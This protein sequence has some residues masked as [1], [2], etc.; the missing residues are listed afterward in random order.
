MILAGSCLRG[1]LQYEVT[2]PLG[3]VASCHCAFC[4]RVHGAAFTTVALVAST[5]ISWLPSSSGPS[6]FRTPLG[7]IRHFCGRC[8][9]PLWNQTPSS[10]LAA[11]VVSSLV[12]GAQP[13]PWM[14]VNIESKAPW[15]TIRD[16]LPQF[17]GWPA[18]DALER[19]LHQHSSS[20]RPHPLVGPAA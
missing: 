13:A 1:A 4:R 9:S 14:H 2:G 12:E 6:R 20:W 16:E 19:L 7:N 5:A 17:V 15:F 3:P 10:G 8:A 11:V 18:R